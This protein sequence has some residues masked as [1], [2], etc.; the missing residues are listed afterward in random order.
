MTTQQ[1]NHRWHWVIQLQFWRVTCE[2]CHRDIPAF[3]T[4]WR[5]CFREDGPDEKGKDC[6]DQCKRKVE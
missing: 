3:T 5:W 4:Y 6:C 2:H 1:Q